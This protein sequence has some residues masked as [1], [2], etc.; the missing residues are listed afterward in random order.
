VPDLHRSQQSWLNKPEF[1]TFQA[2]SA[3]RFFSIT[4]SDGSR[5]T[6]KE[7]AFA[8]GVSNLFKK[9]VESNYSIFRISFQR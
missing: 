1:S 8:H 3:T 5:K 7:F 6:S 9:A 4:L 2:K